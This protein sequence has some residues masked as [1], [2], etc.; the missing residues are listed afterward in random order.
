MGD[1]ACR[2]QSVQ[3][4][5]LILPNLNEFPI[6]LARPN[7]MWQRKFQNDEILFEILSEVNLQILKNNNN[8]V[9]IQITIDDI[10]KIYLKNKHEIKE[11][12]RRTEGQIRYKRTLVRPI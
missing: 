7:R 3:M 9:D 1:S 6:S 5:I 4:A 11:K 8:Y 2:P 12:Q 10:K